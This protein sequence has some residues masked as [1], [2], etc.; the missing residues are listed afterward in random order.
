MRHL[1]C[2]AAGLGLASLLGLG[3]AR[4]S[5]LT[6]GEPPA[7]TPRPPVPKAVPDKAEEG[8]G[9]HGTRVDFLDTPAE[10]VTKAKKEEKLVFVLHVSGHF[11]DPRFT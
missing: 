2:R 5:Q 1:L 8:C 11:E 9:S 3:L 4:G 10:A 7:K 6:G